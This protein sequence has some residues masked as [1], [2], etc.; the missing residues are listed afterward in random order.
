MICYIEVPF[1]ARS[2]GCTYRSI[3]NIQV[4]LNEVWFRRISLYIYN[5][6]HSDNST[7]SGVGVTRSVV[8]HVCFVDRCLSFYP[9]SFAHCVVCPSSISDSDYSLGIFKVILQPIQVV[10]VLFLI[11]SMI[12]ETFVCK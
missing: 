1:K 4:G 9:F 7:I 10:Q 8:L 6:V 11:F 5:L 2:T 12:K 3:P